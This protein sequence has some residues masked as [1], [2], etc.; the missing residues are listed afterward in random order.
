MDLVQ[1]YVMI[2]LCN[3]STS[4]ASSKDRRREIDK[5]LRVEMS[6]SRKA[7]VQNI[8]V[9]LFQMVQTVLVIHFMLYICHSFSYSPTCKSISLYMYLLRHATHIKI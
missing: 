5:F 2:L 8:N 7:G 9:N 3:I 4:L 1:V 6:P